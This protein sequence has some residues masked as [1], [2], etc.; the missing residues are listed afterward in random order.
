MSYDRE[1]DEAAN[2]CR[3]QIEVCDR[4]GLFFYDCEG[5]GSSPDSPDND[6]EEGR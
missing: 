5:H 4:C 6:A 2:G 1:M 3:P